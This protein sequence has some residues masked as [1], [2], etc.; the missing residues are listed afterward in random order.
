MFPLVFSHE[1]GWSILSCN[2]KFGLPSIH[3]VENM[4]LFLYILIDY[5]KQLKE[6][7]LKKHSSSRI[8]N[9]L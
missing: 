7:E 3:A 6:D 9:D 5:Y 4:A 2:F 1:D 8:Y